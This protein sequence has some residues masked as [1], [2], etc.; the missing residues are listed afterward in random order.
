MSYAPIRDYA[1]I[2]DCHGSA[3]VARNGDIDWCCLARFDDAPVLFRLLDAHKGG[4]VS[5]R[6]GE[7]FETER[8]YI[9]N[10]NVL[11]T[12]FTT[13]HG[14][15]CVTDLMP[16]G[17]RPGAGTHNYVDLD[18]P[19]WLIRL[20]EGRAGHVPL[21]VVFRLSNGF[22]N[23]AIPLSAVGTTVVSAAG[24][25]IHAD[26]PFT[27]DGPEA[28]ASITIGPGEQRILVLTPNASTRPLE[29]V[30]EL[31]RITQA[32]WREWIAYCRYDG[33]YAPYVRRSALALKLMTYAPTGA[34]VAAPTTS[35]P[36]R[37][38]GGRNWDYRYCWLRDTTL[39]LYA[40]A[41]LGYG[42]EAR[43]FAAFLR[44]RC[45]GTA[46]DLK[47]LYGIDGNPC[48]AERCHPDLDG[49]CGSRPV[50]TGNA[51]FAQ[52]QVDVYGEIL[53]W[54]L[55]YRAL[56]G[57]FS[58]TDR[59][60]LEQIVER[61]A[62]EWQEPDQGFWESRGP[63]RRHV[64]GQVMSWVAVDRAI[65]LF[66][67]RAAWAEV[68]E[69]IA[70]DVRQNGLGRYGD[71][72][73]GS[74]GD[75]TD[76]A[77]LRLAAV[78]F[79]ISSDRLRRIVR[80]VEREL[81]DGDFIRHYRNH[82]GIAGTEGAFLSCSFWLVDAY[83]CLQQYGRARGLFERICRCSNDVGLL[84]EEIDPS[85]RAFLGNFPQALTH[86]G[87]IIS[88]TKLH[89]YETGGID[90]VLGADADRIRRSVGAILGW[91]AL[92]AAFRHSRRVGRILPSR[93]SVLAL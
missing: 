72:V 85:S 29:R 82:D 56:G 43:R 33:P 15:V 91:R 79:P 55:L 76:A 92:W 2:G 67:H 37:I 8:Q 69:C 86:L 88:A 80:F 71:G 4:F 32:Y 42:G 50:R 28:R 83:L 45:G 11:Q 78:G 22:E 46:D 52:H 27:I 54:A 64:H 44:Q 62:A 58:A 12:L 65:R 89:L 34:I 47:I 16:V 74:A 26:I 61:A 19:H 14:T 93:D 57:R 21:D 84:S 53:D 17:R 70:Q 7:P 59:T 25:A 87:L 51:A 40:L 24:A 36:E 1:M 75:R 63:P 90:A 3:L 39:A 49:Y 5:V 48:P 13:A 30:A 66:G 31:L 81:G 77:L 41:S 35:L 9:E 60:F 73:G 23:P 6:P 68:R 20:M 18:A 38:G 10:T